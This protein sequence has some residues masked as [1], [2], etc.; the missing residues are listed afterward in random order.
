MKLAWPENKRDWVDVYISPNWRGH[1]EGLCCVSTE[2]KSAAATYTWM[3][4][5]EA[6]VYK[7]D[8]TEYKKIKRIG[9]QATVQ[10]LC[11]QSRS[12]GRL[13]RGGFVVQGTSESATG[14]KPHEGVCKDRNRRR[15][16]EG[17]QELACMK[18]VER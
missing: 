6:E 18:T 14:K 12:K 7:D 2:T 4:H 1:W 13:F 15:K 10:Y 8:Q 11:L 9:T 3:W 16:K 17:K 5:N